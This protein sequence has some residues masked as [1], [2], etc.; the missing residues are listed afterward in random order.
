MPA[1]ESSEKMKG[2]EQKDLG[3]GE[4]R[5]YGNPQR[6]GKSENAGIPER[7]K[8]EICNLPVTLV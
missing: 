1:K 2:S 3:D 8:F 5:E 6:E 4:T 7:A